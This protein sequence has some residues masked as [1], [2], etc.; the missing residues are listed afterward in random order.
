MFINIQTLFAVNF[1]HTICATHH[2]GDERYG[3]TAGLQCTPNAMVA[4]CFSEMKHIT[5]WTTEDMDHILQLGDTLY[6]QARLNQKSNAHHQ[7]YLEPQEVPHTFSSQQV[8]HQLYVPPNYT[9]GVHGSNGS[10]ESLLIKL[11]EFLCENKAGLVISC[12]QTVGIFELV[13]VDDSK[14]YAIFDSHSRDM[15][16]H[17]DE[18]CTAVVS[19][20]MSRIGM[21][22][23]LM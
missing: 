23:T 4:I 10:Y 17:I 7:A 14:Y 20:H 5:L 2:Q 16:G 1:P 8:N 19:F 9:Y 12:G 22:K 18:K 3:V 21:T 15:N 13:G 11:W 6:V